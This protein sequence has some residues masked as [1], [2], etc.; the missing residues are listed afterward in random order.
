MVPRKLQDKYLREK[1][2]LTA[3][4]LPSCFKCSLLDSFC[5]VTLYIGLSD[6]ILAIPRLFSLHA[7]PSLCQLDRTSD[8][9]LFK[10]KR[11]F[12]LSIQTKI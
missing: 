12:S 1:L 11:A 4:C 9:F 3:A 10:R 8:G 7:V 2:H 6:S 5:F